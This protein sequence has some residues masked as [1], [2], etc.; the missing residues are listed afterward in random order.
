MIASYARGPTATLSGRWAVHPTPTQR[1]TADSAAP[2]VR[3]TKSG[4]IRCGQSIATQIEVGVGLRLGSALGPTPAIPL[5]PAGYTAAG[6]GQVC[7]GGG[8]C[9]C[10]GVYAGLRF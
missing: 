5:P 6:K 3:A 4:D 2:T 8:V 7:G 9:V 1:S 10:G